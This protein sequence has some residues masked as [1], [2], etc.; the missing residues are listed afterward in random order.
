MLFYLKTIWTAEGGQEVVKPN[1]CTNKELSG[2]SIDLVT[3]RDCSTDPLSGLPDDN[4]YFLPDSDNTVNR[5][6]ITDLHLTL[7]TASF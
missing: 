1:F 3:G 5:S 4:C 6:S 2:V 7:L